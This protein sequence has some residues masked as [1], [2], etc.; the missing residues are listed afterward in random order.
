MQ[1][2][3]RIAQR[4]QGRKSRTV[5]C[6]PCTEHTAIPTEINRFRPRRREHSIEM[7]GNHDGTRISRWPERRHHI[8]GSIQTCRPAKRLELLPKPLGAPLLK[9]SRR[10]NPA[11]LQMLFVDPRPFAC[12]PSQR[13]G[14][15]RDLSQT[16]NTS[17]IQCS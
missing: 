17:R 12:K 13:S 14:D 5:V 1:E 6:R 11:E 9:E 4:Q 7:C 10:R 2:A 8:P 15:G 3:E 16:R